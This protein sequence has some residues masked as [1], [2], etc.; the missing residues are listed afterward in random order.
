M[1]TSSLLVAG[2]MVPAL[3]CAMPVEASAVAELPT[4]SVSVSG[5]G[6]VSVKPDRATVSVGAWHQA[7][8]AIEAQSRVNEIIEEATK[9][10]RKVKAEGMLIQTSGLS[11]S[12]V[13]NYQRDKEP[14]IIGYRASIMLTVRID[15]IDKTGA[16]IDAAMET[17]VNQMH[18][19]SFSLKDDSGA[20]RDA[21]KKAVQ[22][23]RQKAE[24]IAD[25]LG[26][27]IQD[28]IEVSEQGVSVPI[29]NRGIESYRTMAADSA[30][31]PIEAGEIEISASVNISYSL[32]Q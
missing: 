12:P 8:T 31:T 30:A 17:G 32:G 1:N 16:V 25:A 6:T 11:L 28:L 29:I 5:K 2:L 18:G 21:L 4:V 10:I 22:D 9:E 27:P 26:R 7:E 23:G 24:A 15:D 20:R 13:Y 14:K 3:V 19:V